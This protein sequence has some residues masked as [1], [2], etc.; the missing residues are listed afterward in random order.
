MKIKS[1]QK[2]QTSVEYVLLVGVMIAISVAFFGK[3]RGYILDNP[4]SMVNKYLLGFESS[5]N[6]G[7]G[8]YKRFSLKK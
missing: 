3:V 7:A 8:R 1:C 4:D 5:F 2:G 6:G